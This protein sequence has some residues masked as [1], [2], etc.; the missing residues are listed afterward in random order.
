M[1]LESILE[2]VRACGQMILQADRTQAGTEIKDGQTNNLVTK[3]D[4]AVQAALREKL[5]AL[6][7]QAHFVGEEEDVHESIARGDAFIVDP[8][9]GT[10]NFVKDYKCSAVSVAMTRDGVQE[11]GV[12]YNP[13]LDEMF[14]AQRGK[15]AFCNG[16]PI[17]VSDKPLEQGLTLF[18]S[19]SYYSELVDESFRLLR[20]CFDRSMD[21][22]RSGSAAI[23]LCTIAAGRAEL[24]FEL[25]LQP[26][27]F[28]A[29]S[30]I[31]REAGGS[32]TRL[33]GSALDLSQPCPVLAIGT[34]VDPAFLR[35]AETSLA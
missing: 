14:Y 33:D 9:D 12:V 8:I 5:L 23:D 21:I 35:R 1:L 26:W 15:G 10:A 18:G 2:V 22:R 28:A 25:R 20:L 7:P 16:K 34:G 24:F 17:R 31:V 30:L 29:A 27:D 4:R 19:A 13:Y 11:L 3:Y 6:A 32:V